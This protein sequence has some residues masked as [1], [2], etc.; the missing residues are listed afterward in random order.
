MLSAQSDV[1]VSKPRSGGKIF[2]LHPNHICI[3]RR[4]CVCFRKLN[5]FCRFSDAVVAAQGLRKLPEAIEWSYSGELNVSDILP[6][7]KLFTSHFPDFT[8]FQCNP[9]PPQQNQL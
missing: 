7:F 3:L 2:A 5:L 1:A 8:Q 9:A 6:I 4:V